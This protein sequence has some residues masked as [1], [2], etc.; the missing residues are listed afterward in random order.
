MDD[1]TALLNALDELPFPST[2]GTVWRYLGW[3]EAKFKAAIAS[4]EK[5][6]RILPCEDKSEV[7][8]LVAQGKADY[9]NN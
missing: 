3:D 4:L 2:N 5:K 8:V 9:R 6:G 1:E 7:E